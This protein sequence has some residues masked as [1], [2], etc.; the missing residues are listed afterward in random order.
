MI[1]KKILVV[2]GANIE[3][4]LKSKT[5]IIQGSK[6]FVEIEELFGGSGVNYSLR[7]LAYGEDVI[8]LLFVGDDSTGREIYEKLAP[9]G[10]KEKTFFVPQLHTPRSTIL[11]EGIHRTILSQ[12]PNQN[13]IF[14]PFIAK[15]LPTIGEVSALVIGHIHND[16]KEIQ[17]KGDILSTIYLLDY[18]AHK[19]NTLI[20]AN[21]G[22]TQLAYG[23]KYWEKY[24]PQVDIL[25]LNIHELAHFLGDG[26]SY[27]LASL[28]Q[29]IEMLNITTVITLDKFGAIGI[30][31]DV[32]NTLFMVRPINDKENFV[33]STG[34]GD[35]FCAGMVSYLKG[36][37]HFNQDAFKKGMERG[38]SWASYACN[39]FGGA[40]NCPTKS[41]IEHYHNKKTKNNTVVT[42]H[43]SA[44]K[45]I[46]S[47]I[48]SMLK[49]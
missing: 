23:V 22:A 16:R 49:S 35:A 15:K 34:A 7:L 8:P 28:I 43:D 36:N 29:K 11:V 25:Q 30:M 13:N 17:K 6:N 45:D 33:D 38:R 47:L 31:K 41:E 18:Y 9:F 42:Y 32:K 39:S 37:K 48:D 5:D 14:Q 3:Y 2:G 21:F 4:I 10:V 44:M 26:H 46:I 24:L 20:Y 40:N 12:D 19:A 27:D 1:E